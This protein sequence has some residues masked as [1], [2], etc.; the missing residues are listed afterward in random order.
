MSL[1]Q[2]RPNFATKQNGPIDDAAS[3]L[4][5]PLNLQQIQYRGCAGTDEFATLNSCAELGNYVKVS[6]PT[7]DIAVR[8][9][10]WIRWKLP[11]RLLGKPGG[12]HEM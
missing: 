2:H 1:K 4:S 9:D 5:L 12:H 11:V 10:I 7:I 6:N 3:R 8:T